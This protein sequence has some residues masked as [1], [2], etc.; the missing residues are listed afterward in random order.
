MWS[1]CD[2][3]ISN[4]STKKTKQNRETIERKLHKTH[5]FHWW[6]HGYT[7]RAST[8]SLDCWTES[9]FKWEPKK[10]DFWAVVNYLWSI[11]RSVTKYDVWQLM[12]IIYPH[13]VNF[14][15]KKKKLQN[16]KSPQ[17]S[18][19]FQGPTLCFPLSLY[20]KN[21]IPNSAGLFR[22]KKH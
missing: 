8:E 5:I 12:V 19:S 18:P 1:K 17:F 22:Y 11:A 3:K 21:H 9:S 10:C 2:I 6:K 20:D 4:L 7:L 16:R 15:P 13:V 14:S